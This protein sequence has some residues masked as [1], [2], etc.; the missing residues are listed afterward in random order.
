M[1]RFVFLLFLIAV[2]LT[3]GAA[4]PGAKAALAVADGFV[5]PHY[6]ALAAAADAQA[7]AWDLF[8][9]GH[10]RGR[11]QALRAAYHALA[12]RWAEIEFVK[13]GPIVLFLR[14]ERFDY[15]PE[16]RNA[17]QR[18]LD[19]LL[20]SNDPNALAPATLAHDSVPAQ[21][22]P[23]IERLL[24]DAAYARHPK[25]CVI[26]Q[27]VARNLASIAHGVLAEWTA[28][29]GARAAIAADKG[30]NNNIFAGADEAGRMLLTDLVSAFAALNDRKLLA[31]LGA[32]LAAAKPRAAEAWRSGRSARD[33]AL[34]LAAMHE[35]VKFFAAGISAPARARLDRV[36][37]GAEAAVKALPPDI[38]AAAA[39][40]VLRAKLVAARAAIKSAQAET[41]AILPA[42]LNLSVGFN[43]LDGD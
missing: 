1:R 26:G 39:N 29:N 2:P 3:A 17:T 12:D 16:V 25:R 40:P 9:K 5:V 42:A 31:P 37:A 36:F 19:A 14:A 30:W 33:L 8:C 28:P 13:T 10:A 41:L 27:A 18:N 4:T 34:N 43:A 11:E 23:A 22:L 35:M 24:Y 6:R 38:G 20:A 7:R 32:S 21:G 15:W